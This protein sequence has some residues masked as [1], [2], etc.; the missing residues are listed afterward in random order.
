MSLVNLKRLLS[1][2]SNASAIVNAY[3]WSLGIT[4]C[5]QDVEGNVLFGEVEKGAPQAEIRLGDEVLGWVMGMHAELVADVVAKLASDEAEKK[6]LGNEILGLYREMNMLFK[7][8]EKLAS[9]RQLVSVATVALNEASVVIHST[10]G[11]VMLMQGADAELKPIASFG[12]VLVT[13]M[14]L[15]HVHELVDRVI[16]KTEGEIINAQADPPVSVS[17][18]CVPIK[19]DQRTAGVMVLANTAGTAYYSADLKLLNTIG[20][21]TGPALDAAVAY[22][23][24]FRKAREREQELQNQLDSLRIQLDEARKEKQVAEITETE[25]FQKLLERVEQRRRSVS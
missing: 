1:K 4:S 9:V 20:S 11:V 7:L 17:L 14:T 13:Q 2:K 15:P 19:Q 10:D 16:Q 18:V 5:I 23:E 21:L 8:S 25:Y 12:N 3:V 6:S 24:A 22:E